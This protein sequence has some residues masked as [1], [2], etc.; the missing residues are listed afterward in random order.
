MA[1]VGLLPLMLV[2][3]L[4]I[5][6]DSSGPVFFLQERIGSKRR[7]QDG[8]IRWEVQKFKIYK[9][10]TMVKDADDSLHRAYVKAFVHGSVEA[11]SDSAAPFKL[12][13]DP[14]LTGI[15]H[16]LRKTS[17]DEL[18]Q[19]INVLIGDMSLVGPRPVPEYEVAEYREVWH[20]GRLATIPG[21]T[22]LWQ[23]NGRG[24]VSF[25]EMV[26]LDLEYIRRQSLWL[27]LKILLVTV[28][29]VLS[30]RGAE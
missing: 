14:R 24:Q 12:N 2:A 28:P 3:A 26:Q 6:L 5:K 7:V 16:F 27:D 21:I 9:F 29:T 25:E 10:R 13:A 22:G 11:L 23:I 20:H 15:G 8:Q 18:P 17:L 4:L 19:L 1:L 30:G